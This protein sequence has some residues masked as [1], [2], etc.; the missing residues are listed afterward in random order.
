MAR[1]SLSPAFPLGSAAWEEG[2][3]SG[4]WDSSRG[5]KALSSIQPTRAFSTLGPPRTTSTD[6]AA[7]THANSSVSV[8][9]ANQ[10][11]SAI[12]TGSDQLG[13][14]V[15]SPTG[16]TLDA[17]PSLS[18]LPISHEGRGDNSDP[19]GTGTVGGVPKLPFEEPL[20]EEPTDSSGPFFTTELQPS[21]SFP[22]LFYSS[23]SSSSSSASFDQMLKDL[24]RTTPELAPPH[25]ITLREVHSSVSGESTSQGE[26]ESPTP[27]LKNLPETPSLAPVSHS[28]A[29][30]LPSTFPSLSLNLTD[31]TTEGEGDTTGTPVS[32][33]TDS[34]GNTTD[35]LSNTTGSHSNATESLSNTTDS[36]TNTIDSLSNATGARSATSW[37]SSPGGNGSATTEPAS[38]A[39]GNFLNRQ[40]PAATL[41]PHT[42]GNHSGPALDSQHPRATLC[43]GKMDIV[44]IVLAISV[45]VSSCSVLLTVCC[46]KRKK[47][48]SSQENNLSY[49]NNTITMDY[50]NRHAVELPREIQSIETAEEQETCLPPNGDLT[51][52]GMVLVN[53]F[54]QETL[55]INRDKASNI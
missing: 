51:E 55:F 28:L 22:S 33:A 36:L 42:P 38:T 32:N 29:S 49:W 19:A 24:A 50:F 13:T 53:P 26:E 1:Q 44:W 16:S 14:E 41:G 48:A 11:H 30:A 8:Y 25:A 20:L 43:L 27:P 15:S 2:S 31:P 35:S 21:S 7:S 23:S 3:S 5:H 18:P 12:S 39:T 45:P 54:C 47:K 46:M 10:V 9:T 52:S 6:V 34:L 4:A 17:G 40:V 37:S